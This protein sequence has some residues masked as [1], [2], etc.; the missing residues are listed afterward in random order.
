MAEIRK[1]L[2]WITSEIDRVKHGRRPS[3]KQAK[4]LQCLKQRFLGGKYGLSR[5][6]GLKEKQTHIL[7]IH[8]LK[9]KWL[10]EREMRQ[11]ET[12]QLETK[13]PKT[14][15]QGRRSTETQVKEMRQ[16]WKGVWGVPGTCD[17]AHLAVRGWRDEMREW[18]DCAESIGDDRGPLPR[19]VAWARAIKKQPGWKAPGPDG[20]SG[21]W[22]RA[23]LSL[24]RALEGLV[25]G[26]LDRTVEALGWLV[27]GRT[28]MI[29]KENC[30]GR[31][32]Q[33]R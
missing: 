4:R 1:M 30:R 9:A 31:P 14:W 3:K 16:F 32:E 24:T 23:F 22:L 6:R 17:L 18:L 7:K 33:Y 21:F 12:D 13:G 10:K 15:S 2:G 27:A 28:I 19:K 5:F 25:W 8:A 29:E 11:A 20:I 26:T